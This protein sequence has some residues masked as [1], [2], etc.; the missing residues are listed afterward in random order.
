MCTYTYVH[1]YIV[2]ISLYIYIYG[3][4]SR[5]RRAFVSQTPVPDDLSLKNASVHVSYHVRRQPGF[6]QS[7][8]FINEAQRG[9]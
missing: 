8:P 1:T 4:L 3:F 2:Y 9:P 5:A 6:W 7:W